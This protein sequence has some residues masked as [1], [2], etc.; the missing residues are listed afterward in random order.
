MGLGRT[1]PWEGG[2]R[3]DYHTRSASSGQRT[4]FRTTSFAEI[5]NVM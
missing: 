2:D 3:V 1:G 4:R 5:C